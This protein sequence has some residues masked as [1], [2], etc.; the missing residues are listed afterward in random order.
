MGCGQM[1]TNTWKWIGILALG[2]I[3]GL[4]DVFSDAKFPGW[5]DLV[6]HVGAGVVVAAVALKTTLTQKQ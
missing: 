3:G 6:R 5:W 4:A 2:G 1:S